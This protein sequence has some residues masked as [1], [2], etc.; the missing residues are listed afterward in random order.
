VTSQVAASK[1][2]LALGLAALAWAV[3]VVY[4]SLVPLDFHYRP[5]VAAWDAFL[6]TPYLRLG[7]GSRADWVA[8][9]LLY[10]PLAFLATGWLATASRSRGF[11]AG[12]AVFIFCVLLAIAVEFTQ[13]YFP[14]RTVSLNDIVAEIIGSAL[15]LVLWLSAG[16]RVIALWAEVQ[17][18]GPA[19]GRALTVLYTSAYLAFAL[20][21]YDFLVSPGE[22][23]EKL[24]DPS[25]FAILVTYSC[26]G[27]FRCS[28]KLLSEILT[29]A[30]LGIFLGMVTTRLG[31]G[32]AFC[33]GLLL[34]AVIEALQAVLASGISQGASIFTRGMGV[35]LGL[36]A[37]RAFRREW[38][39]QYRAPMRVAVLLALP[40]YL[41]FLMAISGFFSSGLESRWIALAK[42]RE[43]RFLPFY[44]HYYT[45]ETQAMYSLLLHVAAY[46][47]IGVAV[48]IFDRAG[49]RIGAWI[50]A[51]A[52]AITA[53]A[54]E[55][56]KL[57]LNGRRPDPTDVLIAAAAAACAYLLASRLRRSPVAGARPEVASAP[58]SQHAERRT[59]ILGA[60]LAA[61]AVIGVI[62]LLAWIMAGPSREHMVD[63][64]RL[65]Q[66][67][68]PDD[69]P[70][71]NLP[72]F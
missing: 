57:F 67:P 72:A 24:A 63:E 44:Y 60:G 32:K 70:S 2:T 6:Q 7:V 34:G 33:W 71:V 39:T 52:A 59:R 16:E 41:V 1:P 38:L 27:S 65:P 11:V 42:L 47:P 36:A 28:A 10:I 29:V 30:P 43:V 58:V 3:F 45:S 25:R 14:P 50:A 62:A 68:A 15:G 35:T 49:G 21:P 18:G 53:F 22:L 66:L 61:G 31:L 40:L 48:W 26:G 56:L 19:S 4:G 17:L 5:L 8:N 64:S 20:F 46:A 23:A 12:M 54:I 9:I 69:L 51:L 37:H 13:L 55:A